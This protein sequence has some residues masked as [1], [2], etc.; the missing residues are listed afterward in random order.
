MVPTH[1]DVPGRSVI[2][3]ALAVGDKTKCQSASCQQY[4]HISVHAGDWGGTCQPRDNGM[5]DLTWRSGKQYAEWEEKG[6]SS[7]AA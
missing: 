2:M 5:L 7:F 3:G 6:Y 1:Q 4:A